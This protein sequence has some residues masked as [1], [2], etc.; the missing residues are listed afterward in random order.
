MATT[1]IN[2]R[3]AGKRL[4]TESARRSGP[5]AITSASLSARAQLRRFENRGAGARDSIG[6]E[7]ERRREQARRVIHRQPK[8]IATAP[9]A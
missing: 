6:D 8:T 7:F 3:P 9:R 1:K 2:N 5:K 4:T